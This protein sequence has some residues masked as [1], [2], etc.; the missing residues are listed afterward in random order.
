MEPHLYYYAIVAD[1]GE[2]VD[3]AI[4]SLT[5]ES[6]WAL[7]QSASG[8][9]GFRVLR[10]AQPLVPPASPD[11]RIERIHQDFGAHGLDP[12][13]V[14]PFPVGDSEQFGT[15]ATDDRTAMLVSTGSIPEI[16]RVVK[17]FVSPTPDS[18]PGPDA[19]G[20][21]GADSN[22]NPVP[23]GSAPTGASGDG[24]AACCAA[25]TVAAA[26]PAFAD[27]DA[28]WAWA[29]DG[30]RGELA[31][32][33]LPDLYAE[34]A[35][36]A[37]KAEWALAPELVLL[38]QSPTD[39]RPALAEQLLRVRGGLTEADAA[40]RDSRAALLGKRVNLATHGVMIAA[41]MLEQMRKWRSIAKWGLAALVVNSLVA[42]FALIY[43]FV[44]LI[45]DGKIGEVAAPIIIFALAVFAISPAMLLL[46][47][48]PLEGID[49][50]SPSGGAAGSDNSKDES[51]KK[52]KDKD[53]GSE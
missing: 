19:K 38:E 49:K 42:I 8:S 14:S 50:W 36:F 18:D 30:E 27:A 29:E 33:L 25:A 22:G 35:R 51:G 4:S 9:P 15:A 52:E 48:R 10:L 7:D 20:A 32:E 11:E 1:S 23:A 2:G 5:K 53:K 28:L 44:H 26:I 6:A 12:L 45:P 13:L 24:T 3:D 40:A 21:T 47:E 46:R 37:A 41:E 16:G 17:G 43:L 31:R 34:R 39:S